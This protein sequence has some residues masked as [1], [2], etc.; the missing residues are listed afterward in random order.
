MYFFGPLIMPMITKTALKEV[1]EILAPGQELVNI[2]LVSGVPDEGVPGR[3]K[4]SVQSDGQL[5]HT[6]V[7][8]QVTA[9]LRNLGDEEMP[10]LSG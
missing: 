7:W 1:R 10:D 2:R 8:T 3:I 4:N 6:K 5:H 9:G